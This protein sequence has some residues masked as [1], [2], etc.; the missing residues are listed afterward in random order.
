MH[1]RLF[2]VS[3]LV[4]IFRSSHRL[5][6]Y[7]YIRLNFQVCPH[8]PHSLLR[9]LSRLPTTPTSPPHFLS[10]YLSLLRIR[11]LVTTPYL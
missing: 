2:L 3:L 7:L 6:I 1:V 5:T 10:I 9:L 11:S 4:L 8:Q